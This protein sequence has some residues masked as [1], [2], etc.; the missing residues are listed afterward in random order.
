[1]PLK[2]ICPTCKNRHTRK[3]GTL[4]GKQRIRCMNPECPRETFI[5]PGDRHRSRYVSRAHYMRVYRKRRLLKSYHKSQRSDW[6]TPPDLFA[7]LDVEFHFTLDACATP[8]NAKCPR[9]YSEA[10]NALAQEWVGAVWCNP[11]YGHG[12][13]AWVAKAQESARAGATVVCLVKAT[14]DTQ[15]WHQHTPH[16]EVRF[17]PGRLRF[18]GAENAAPFP[19]CLVIFRPPLTTD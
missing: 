15:W 10:E 1:M 3:E 9:F 5:L 2:T 18:V 6:E 16:A 14:P 7:A 13:G 4:R 19:S 17:L 11:P 12:V 8:Q